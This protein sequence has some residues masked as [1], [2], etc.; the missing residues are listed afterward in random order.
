MVEGGG[1]GEAGP[2]FRPGSGQP[3]QQRPRH[4]EEGHHHRRRIAGQAEE[5][6]AANPADAHRLARLDGQPP[7]IEAAAGRRHRRAQ[8]ILLAHRHAAG[9]D[10]GVVGCG[11]GGQ[12]FGDDVRPVGQNAEIVDGAAHLPEQA[13]QGVTVAVVEAAGGQGLS[14]VAQLVASGEHRHPRPPPHHQPRGSR[15]RRQSEFRRPQAPTRRQRHRSGGEI[16]TGP[17]DVGAEGDPRRQGDHAVAG[18]AVLLHHHGV[19]PGR[20]RRAGED[21]GGMTARQR[22]AQGMAG[23]DPR[24][25]RQG[26]LAIG[27]EVGKGHG[28]AV[29]RRVVPGGD[30]ERGPHRFG[31]HAAE[32]RRQRHRFDRRDR[33]CQRQQLGEDAGETG[34]LGLGSGGTDGRTH[35]AAFV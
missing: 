15:R 28:V 33:R 12:G 30:V 26:G 22:S 5:Q 13:E 18:A 11:G 21:A 17:P 9:G 31:Q 7:V 6:G 14:G 2:A 4:Q 19:G 35:G 27:L 16:V 32:R 25:H 8:M 24:R 20:H 29:H 34:R 1:R 23:G 3:L 10:E